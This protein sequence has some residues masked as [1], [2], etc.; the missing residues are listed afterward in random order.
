MSY[1]VP[2]TYSFVCAS[3]NGLVNGYGRIVNVSRASITVEDNFSNSYYLHIGVCS[4]IMGKSSSSVPQIGDIIDWSGYA[5][6][7]N[8]YNLIRASFYSIN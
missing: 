2:S 4:K 1:G 7:P 3:P 6:T 5:L 8:V